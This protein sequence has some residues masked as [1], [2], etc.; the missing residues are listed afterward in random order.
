MPQPHK[1]PRIFVVHGELVIASTLAAILRHQ[2]FDARFFTASP[3]ALQAARSS[4]PDLLIS[5]VAMPQ[6][7]GIELAIAVHQRRPNCRVLLFC[8]EGAS[9]QLFEAAR[10][11][12]LDFELL[13][14]PVYP[15]KL[16]NKIQ[17]MIA[18]PQSQF[19]P[20]R[21]KAGH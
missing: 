18:A 2:G 12:G 10:A 19:Y 6:L 3:D 1:H 9:A 14:K 5:D 8:A 15:T 16:L 21:P 7:P 17:Q 20:R 13:S 11:E 4:A